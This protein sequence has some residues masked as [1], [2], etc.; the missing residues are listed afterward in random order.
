MWFLLAKRFH[1]NLHLKFH[2]GQREMPGSPEMIN[3]DYLRGM[4]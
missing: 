4:G 1:S 3:S 2:A